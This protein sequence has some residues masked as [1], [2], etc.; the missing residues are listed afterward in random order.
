[1][2]DYSGAD[3]VVASASASLVGLLIGMLGATQVKDIPAPLW[4]LAGAVIG[5]ILGFST[6]FWLDRIRRRTELHDIKASLYAEVA[7][8]AARCLSDY[9]VPWQA[10]ENETSTKVMISD[11]IAKYRPADPV[12]YT[13]VAGKLG[14][15]EPQ[16]MFALNHF[17]FRL[18]ALT[19]EIDTFSSQPRTALNDLHSRKRLKIIPARLRSTFEPALRALERLNV[20]N[21][22]RFDQEAISE[23]QHIR[24]VGET[25]RGGLKKH[26]RDDL[27]K[28][29][30]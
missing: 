3:I 16:I 22:E 18:Q 6:S 2:R 20:P 14:L 19:R 10:I 28:T 24:E 30:E 27:T 1:M 25:L 17:Y 13:S 8:R 9:I 11:E 23:Y 12:V 7:D 26:R 15:L 29:K 4:T 5:G 21:F